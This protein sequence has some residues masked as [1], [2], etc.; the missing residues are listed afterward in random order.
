MNRKIVTWAVVPICL[1]LI[2]MGMRVPPM[3]GPHATP[4]PR[5]RA[6][7]ENSYKT[8]QDATANDVLA[9][10]LSHQIP[11]PLLQR[12]FRTRVSPETCLFSSVA[13]AKTGARAPP[14]PSC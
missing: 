12:T 13:P 3:G 9:L 10:Q 14:I 6:V 2:V 8:A 4:K 7:V 1:F 5:P 11:A